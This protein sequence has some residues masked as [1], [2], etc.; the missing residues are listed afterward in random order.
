M[1]SEENSSISSLDK[2]DIERQAWTDL[3]ASNIIGEQG[4]GIVTR[5]QAE[6]ISSGAEEKE[7]NIRVGSEDECTESES[8]LEE[9]YREPVDDTNINMVDE[10]RSGENIDPNVSGTNSQSGQS[11]GSSGTTGTNGTG[12]IMVYKKDGVKVKPL[13]TMEPVQVRTFLHQVDVAE[14]NGQRISIAAHIEGE[15]LDTLVVRCADTSNNEMVKD[16]LRKIKDKEMEKAKTQPMDLIKSGLV[17]SKAADKSN[18]QKCE[19]FFRKLEVMLHFINAEENMRVGTLSRERFM[20]AVVQKLPSGLMIQPKQVEFNQNWQ[21]YDGLKALVENRLP[22]LEQTGT[23]GRVNQVCHA[24]VEYGQPVE[25]SLNKVEQAIFNGK[26]EISKQQPPPPRQA[27]RGQYGHQQPQQYGHPQ[28]YGQPQQ[29][30]YGAPQQQYGNQGQGQGAPR[31]PLRNIP[32]MK[33]AGPVRTF[34]QNTFSQAVQG[35]GQNQS[36]MQNMGHQNQDMNQGGG[37]PANQEFFPGNCWTCG[38]YGHKGSQCTVPRND[39]FFENLRQYKERQGQIFNLNSDQTRECQLEVGTPG[40]AWIQVQGCLD[41]G[42]DGNV[43]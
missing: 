27:P 2:Q 3:T 40:G 8:E 22:L 43:Q 6:K 34:G 42:A 24:P 35:N 20:E 19:Q 12:E 30:Q 38:Q 33:P 25:Y 32:V 1:T 17:W 41:S 29:Q 31:G 36:N 26:A 39:Q 7:K 13:T 9:I 10:D 21:T 23:R 28:Q 18:D 4:E 15:A 5:A 37:F 16:V 11:N 14:K